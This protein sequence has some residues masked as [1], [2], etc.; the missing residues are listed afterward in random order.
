MPLLAGLKS[1][2]T[3]LRTTI[4]SGY[5][6]LYRW[7]HQHRRRIIPTLIILA[8]I[9]LTIALI[10]SAYRGVDIVDQAVVINH[11]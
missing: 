11:T 1:K 9:A 7:C 8:C 6:K 2:L 5:N 4:S 3:K 10:I